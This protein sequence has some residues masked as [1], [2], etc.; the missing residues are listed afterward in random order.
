V[1]LQSGSARKA[2]NGKNEEECFHCAGKCALRKCLKS[3]AF[4]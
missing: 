4:E 3:F 1:A 2:K